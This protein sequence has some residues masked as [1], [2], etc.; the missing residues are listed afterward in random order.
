MIGVFCVRATAVTR[1]R[2]GYWN[3]KQQW[4]LTPGKKILP[5]LLPGTE[6]TTIRSEPTSI[7]SWVRRY[8]WTWSPPHPLC[9]VNLL[10]FH[11]FYFT[12]E[13]LIVLHPVVCDEHQLNQICIFTQSWRIAFHFG[14]NFC[15]WHWMGVNI[16]TQLCLLPP[17]FP[18]LAVV[19][20]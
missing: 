11:V 8:Q 16:T 15:D 17:F 6:P 5:P 3:K 14:M 10:L 4:R 19:A 9:T 20:I 7:R 18:S 12:H 2:N 13:E 1:G